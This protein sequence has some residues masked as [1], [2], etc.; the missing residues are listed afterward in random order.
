MKRHIFLGVVKM[1]IA[2]LLLIL[3]GCTA[4]AP[5]TT[6]SSEN[7]PVVSTIIVSRV[8]STSTPMVATQ[9]PLVVPTLSPTPVTTPTPTILP[10]ATETPVAIPTPPNGEIREQVLWLFE[11]NNGCLLPCWWGITP[12]QTEWSVAE[13]F[14]NRFDLYIQKSSWGLPSTLGLV[15]YVPLIPLLPEVFTKDYTEPWIL[16]RDNLV[17]RIKIDV[18]IGASAPDYFTQYAL[19]SFLTTYGQPTEVWLATYPSSFEY[20]ELPFRVVLFYQEQGIV[21]LYDDNGVRQEAVV[22]GCPQQDLV[23]ALS[24]WSPA[25]NLTFEEAISYLAVFNYHYLSLEESTTMDIAT[26]YEVFK[27]PDNTTCLE[28][29]ANLWP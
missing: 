17:E 13:A 21:A 28:T 10:V 3:A 20:N 5:T 24:L 16:V 12:G 11:T 18:S 15:Y 4:Y 26:F 23:K 29:P 2:N 9:T 25:L 7:L 19:S 14:L 22:H 8:S 6:L 27:N 1:S